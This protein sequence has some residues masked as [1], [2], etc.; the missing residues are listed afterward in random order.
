MSI[1]RGPIFFRISLLIVACLVSL[2][3]LSS[4]GF[5]DDW[6]KIESN[7]KF[8]LYYNSLLINIDN[9]NKIIKVWVKYYYTEKGKLEKLKKYDHIKEL[10][11]V[12]NIT[13]KIKDIEYYTILYLINYKELKYNSSNRLNYNNKDKP[14]REPKPFYTF[15]NSFSDITSG[16]IEELILNY[17]IKNYNIK[18]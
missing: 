6:V 16:S 4:F 8:T 15:P 14:I 10:V 2:S 3:T 1:L 5:C 18:R 7:D 9:N 17:L 13:D 11:S 12:R